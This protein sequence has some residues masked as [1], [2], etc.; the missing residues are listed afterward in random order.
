LVCK[1]KICKD[2]IK[3]FSASEDGKT[4]KSTQDLTYDD[5]KDRLVLELFENTN[6]LVKLYEKDEDRRN[7]AFK[8]TLE[9]LKIMWKV[10]K[11]TKDD[12][13]FLAWKTNQYLNKASTDGGQEMSSAVK[14]FREQF[15][16]IFSINKNNKEIVPVRSLQS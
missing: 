7:A 4:L 14:E 6:K 11:D 8:D 3:S 15:A 10:L 13:G 1:D 2:K 9:I 12:K 16:F 5:L